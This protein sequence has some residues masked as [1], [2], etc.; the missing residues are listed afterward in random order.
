MILILIKFLILFVYFL[1]LILIVLNFYLYNT[2]NFICCFFYFIW[3]KS[4]RS[5][6]RRRGPNVVGIYGLLK[7]LQ[8]DLNYFQRKQLFLVYL[9]LLCYSSTNIY[10]C[11]KFI[12]MMFNAFWGKF[13]YNDVNIGAILLLAISSLNVYGVFY[14]DELVILNMR[15]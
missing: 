5:I 2:I 7:L 4:V 8:M 3:T 12:R 10:F 11:I 13:S 9:I 14:L 15:F 1:L 6:Q